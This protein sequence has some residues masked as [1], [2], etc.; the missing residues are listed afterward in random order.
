MAQKHIANPMELVL[1]GFTRGADDLGHAAQTAGRPHA[2]DVQPAVRRIT[3]DDL[4]AALREG[5]SDLAATRADVVFVALIYPVA[6]IV[7]AQ[8]AFNREL[9]PLLFPLLSGFALLGPLAA[10]GLYEM[11][12]RREAGLPV[13]WT[14]AAKVFRSPA[15]G[16]ILGLGAVLLTLFA[17]WLMAAYGVYAMTLGHNPPS[18]VGAFFGEV[19]TTPT[20]WLMTAIGCAVGFV[21]AS[22]A[23]AISV[24]SFPLMLD[25]GVSLGTAVQTSVRA[26]QDNP[27]VMGAWGAVIAGLLVAG[28]IPAL[29]GLIVVMP[30]LGHASWR[31]YRRVVAPG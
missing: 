18:S 14:D 31:L 7:L 25:R 29:I 9:V 4:R 28:T 17:G 3:Y 20:G 27:R 10:L 15:L 16:S 24:V 8:M 1:E 21:F 26:V 19:L 12:R 6:G 2:A 5:W 13:H 23:F 11:S 30:L 22:A